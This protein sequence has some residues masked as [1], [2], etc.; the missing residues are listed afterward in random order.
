MVRS[1]GMDTIHFSIG[2]LEVAMS[3]ILKAAAI[4]AAY[5]AVAFFIGAAIVGCVINYLLPY[6]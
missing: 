2:T 1:L 4:Y 5:A 6:L 3:R